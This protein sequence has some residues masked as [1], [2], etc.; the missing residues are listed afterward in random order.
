MGKPSTSRGAYG[1]TAPSASA[2]RPAANTPKARGV[3]RAPWEAAPGM[4]TAPARPAPA[5][6]RLRG[7]DSG[8]MKVTRKRCR[9]LATKRSVVDG[10]D[11]GY[12]IS[13]MP[14]RRTA[15]EA[16]FADEKSRLMVKG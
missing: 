6:G 10:A 15:A 7:A 5:F 2:S 11:D 12:E 4:A 13:A 16:S 9:D 1:R 14:T 8:L 3:C